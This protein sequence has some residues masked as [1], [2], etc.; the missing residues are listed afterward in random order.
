MDDSVVEGRGG[1][2]G[3]SETFTMDELDR[4]MKQLLEVQKQLAVRDPREEIGTAILLDRAHKV[5]QILDGNP[6]LASE[7]TPAVLF[8][9]ALSGKPNILK[10]ALQLGADVNTP[11]K[12]G[13]PTLVSACRTRS[14]TNPEIWKTLLDKGVDVH[15]GD[16]HFSPLQKAINNEDADLIKALI[17][18]GV[19][20]NA[21]DDKGTALYFALHMNCISSFYTLLKAGA[22]PSITHRG[23]TLLHYVPQHREIKEGAAV[24]E[25]LL[26]AGAE[27]DALDKKGLTPFLVAVSYG[28]LDLMKLFVQRGANLGAV[29]S[30]GG[31]ALWVF[32]NSAIGVHH[33]ECAQWL[34]EQG[35][36]KDQKVGKYE[37]PVSRLHKFVSGVSDSDVYANIAK[38]FKA[39]GARFEDDDDAEDG[40]APADASAAGG[41]EPH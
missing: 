25:A 28:R 36:D 17:D 24:C 15:K 13:M 10:L 32:V 5:Q 39:F 4:R 23:Q 27:I 38:I 7:Y 9:S 37:T 2:A 34:L 6:E 18:H 8:A 3:P 11:A 14:T 26:E 1:A 19:D 21:A 35:V 40:S 30:S 33:P 12:D 20:P 41:G 22:D 31:N 16:G 29:D